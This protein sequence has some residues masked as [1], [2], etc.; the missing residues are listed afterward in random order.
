[1]SITLLLLTDGSPQCS[2]LRVSDIEQMRCRAAAFARG[3]GKS[4]L[5]SGSILVLALGTL[6]T[7]LHY[8]SLVVHLVI[9]LSLLLAIVRVRG[10]Q[11]L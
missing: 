8:I 4:G 1:M 11:F 3:F 6:I 2:Q 9:F 7:T 5:S 10:S